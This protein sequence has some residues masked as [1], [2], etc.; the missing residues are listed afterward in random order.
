MGRTRISAFQ[1]WKFGP[2]RHGLWGL[3][4]GEEAEEHEEEEQQ[5][6]EGFEADDASRVSWCWPSFLVQ[7][8]RPIH[9]CQ[10]YSCRMHLIFAEGSHWCKF[11]LLR[12][13]QLLR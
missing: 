12:K 10:S 5:E 3:W 13:F 2:H 11:H 6:E 1:T 8:F 4:S 9:I 7:G